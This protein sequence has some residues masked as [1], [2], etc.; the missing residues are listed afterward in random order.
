L[1]DISIV[2]AIRKSQ[3]LENTSVPCLYRS[4]DSGILYGIF[5]RKG[6]QIKKISQ[7]H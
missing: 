5:S 2:E 4:S 7:D 1:C 3:T 6:D